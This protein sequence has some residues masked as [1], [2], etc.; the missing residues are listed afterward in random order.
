MKKIS[1]VW[2]FMELPK[3]TLKTTAILPAEHCGGIKRFESQTP[4]S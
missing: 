4:A 3:N 2:K 1:P